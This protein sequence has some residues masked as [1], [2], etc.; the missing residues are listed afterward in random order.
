M[1]GFIVLFVDVEEI[2]ARLSSCCPSSFFF[3][4]Q[5]GDD[6]KVNWQERIFPL[7]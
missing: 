5:L 3:V 6:S 7:H 1:N 4:L 2:K